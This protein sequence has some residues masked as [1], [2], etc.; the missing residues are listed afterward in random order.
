[1]A[2]KRI[3]AFATL[4]TQNLKD[5]VE[6]CRR[7]LFGLRLNAVASHVKDYS[8]FKKLRKDIARGLTLL[9]QKHS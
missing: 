4:D 8:Q 2:R 3:E 6:E 9:T 5:K 7:E 1:M